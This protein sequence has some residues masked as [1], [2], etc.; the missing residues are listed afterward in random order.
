MTNN[1]IQI[2][3]YAKIKVYWDDKPENY[4]RESKLKVRNYF[5][6]KYGVEKP[7]INVIYRP[8]KIGKNGEIIEITGAGIDNIMDRNYQV[9]LM[10]EWFKREGKT[11]DFNRVI[12]L[13]T[14]VN[15]SLETS[16]DVLN[17]RSWELKWIYIDNFLCYGDDNFV[18]FSN[19]KGLNIVNSIPSN[20]GGKTTFSVDAIKF[21]LYGRT[22]KTDKNEQVFNSWRDKN[23]LAVRGL[24]EIEGEEVIIQRKLSRNEKK[25][26]G[27]TVTNRVTY[28]KLLPD[29]EEV[30]MDEADAKQTTELIKQT[31]GDEKDF[32]YTILATASTLENL[33]EAKATESGRLLT[34]FIGL[35]IIEEKE[36][37]AKKFNSEFNKNKM[38]NIYSVVTLLSDNE[39]QALNIVTYDADLARHRT[40]L[41]ISKDE[42]EKLEKERERLLGNKLNVDVTISSLNPERI[43]SEITRITQ[44]GLNYK[45]KIELL[46][47]DI[48]SMSKAT[49]D[50]DLY[51]EL[52]NS[53]TQDTIASAIKDNE[54]RDI[55][56]L[57]DSLKTGEICQTCNR[58]LDDVNNA[59]NIALNKTL[60]KKKEVEV[61]KTRK[62]LAILKQK[63]DNIKIDKDLV[64]KRNRLELEKDKAEVEIGSLRNELISLKL[65]LDKY[66]TNEHA[67][68][69]NLEIDSDISAVK[70]NI[71]VETRTKEEILKKI[72]ATESVIDTA[73]D[74]IKNNE[75]IIEKLKAEEEIEKIFKV[76][77]EMIGKK[78]IS[79]LVLRS[80]LPIINSEL[81]RLMD[82]VCDF[83]IEL[84]MTDKNEVE[85]IIIND[86]VENLLKSGSGLE[87]TISSIALRCVLGKISHLPMPNFISFDE[88]LG[89]LSAE[90]TE[91]VRPMFEK[92]KEMY[93]IV[94]LITH[95]DIVKDWGDRIITSKKDNHI[96]KINVK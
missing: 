6:D 25:S 33:V 56:T 57:I 96:A 22:T 3:R 19:L 36:V 47:V 29:G 52:S 55:G 88:V 60:K 24:I 46:E 12:A 15:G 91:K 74:S 93:D 71:V 43:E 53:H 82:D 68:K 41:D 2:P 49:Y 51:F 76:Y 4:S 7:N 94:F 58:P 13:D 50:E 17:H 81:Q 84:H 16:G 5:A 34:K 90:N 75:S 77:L 72:Y 18:S 61:E 23:T 11:V 20:Q 63:L 92:V 78:G 37:I 10:R 42:L 67:I 83:T 8:V 73:K 26:G 27:W 39:T 85:Y 87:L 38:G 14:K 69:I 89:K 80:V 62:K 45:E 65:D 54:I 9:E 48:E 79:K 30:K 70:T 28:Y 66:K 31:I 44:V 59:E 64:N 95:E 40:N 32:D 21:L 86:G 1:D 35:E